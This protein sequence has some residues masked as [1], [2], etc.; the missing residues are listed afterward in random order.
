MAE[1]IPVFRNILFL[2]LA[3]GTIV[4]PKKWAVFCWLLTAHLDLSGFQW[5]SASAFGWQNTVRVIILP[6]LL[7]FRLNGLGLFTKFSI[8]GGLWITLSLYAAL[9]SLWSPYSL[10]AVKQLGY[11]YSYGI[12]FLL[13]F[14][15]WKNELI[16]SK[17]ISLYVYTVFG[18]ALLQSFVLGNEFGS[19]INDYSRFTSFTSRQS[20]AE[21]LVALLALIIFLPNIKTFHK[22]IMAGILLAEILLNGSRIGII[23]AVFVLAIAGLLL[24]KTTTT[25]RFFISY[26]LVSICGLLLV[27]LYGYSPAI[28]EK[29]QLRAAD[30]VDVFSGR[31]ELAD[32]GTFQFRI[33]IW[34]ATLQNI[35]Y[36]TPAEFILGRGTSSGAEVAVKSLYWRYHPDSVDANRVLHNEFL[37]IFYEWGIV[38]L[39]IF[40]AFL[41]SVIITTLSLSIRFTNGGFAFFALIPMIL[42]TL[43]FENIMAAGGSAGGIGF[44]LVMGYALSNSRTV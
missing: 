28:L 35:H 36:F 3:I 38:G 34:E 43:I 32:I 33:Q 14:F 12:S 41:I 44:M 24:A 11:L 2:V 42:I 19:S 21:S 27:A 15:A 4:L 30:L 29:Y 7:L 31:T 40:V 13:L 25:Y 20:F 8:S 22:I 23:G 6:S 5:L 39:L 16:D 1:Q 37:R 10:S 17:V 18:M 26:C 9:A